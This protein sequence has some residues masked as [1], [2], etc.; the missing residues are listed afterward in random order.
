M[1][2]GFIEQVIADICFG[3]VRPLCLVKRGF[4]FNASFL[5]K[6]ELVTT[7]YLDEFLAGDLAQYGVAT[8]PLEPL[9]GRPATLAL[10][11][12]VLLNPCTDAQ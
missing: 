5:A 2:L 8:V 3:P 10:R 11:I 7:E 6:G 9:P 12:P 1:P 4:A